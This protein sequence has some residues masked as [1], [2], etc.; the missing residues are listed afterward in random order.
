[1]HPRTLIPALALG[2]LLLSAGCSFHASAG[3]RTSRDAYD[4]QS[5]T[6]RTRSTTH[7]RT[8]RVRSPRVTRA[9][10]THTHATST[11]R[12]VRRSNRSSS[13]A[14]PVASTQVV[15]SP[16][17]STGRAKPVAT[18]RANPSNV[19]HNEKPVDG[20]VASTSSE[21]AQRLRDAEAALAQVRADK[22]A[23]DA[24]AKK[25]LQEQERELAAALQA[26]RDAEA[27]AARDMARIRAE[28]EAEM[29]RIRSEHELSLK[30]LEEEESDETDPDKAGMR[31]MV[32]RKNS[33][34][35]E[36]R[37]ARRKELQA[38][39]LSKQQSANSQ[40]H[41]EEAAINSDLDQAHDSLAEAMRKAMGK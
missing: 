30:K 40:R 5:H 14:T 12:V 35:N 6:T 24:A 34:V 2:A 38:A 31:R 3:T 13:R 37:E 23:A 20:A 4:S 16:N 36:A 9:D 8:T 33:Q 25:R 10:R 15:R 22:A 32:E 21:H 26:A 41:S 11:A 1:M 27:K 39:M 28:H 19:A 29:A 18:V 7:A 17:R